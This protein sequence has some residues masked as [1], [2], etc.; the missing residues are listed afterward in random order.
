MI[1]EH[2]VPNPLTR[3]HFIFVEVSEDGQLVVKFIKRF[4]GDH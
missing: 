1:I 2:Q 3:P 4:D